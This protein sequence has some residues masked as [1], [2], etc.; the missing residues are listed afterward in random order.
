MYVSLSQLKT[1]SGRL[2]DGCVSCVSYMCTVT[3]CNSCN[4]RLCLSYFVLVHILQV[5]QISQVT[6]LPCELPWFS[7][8]RRTRQL[9]NTVY[10]KLTLIQTIENI[11]LTSLVGIRILL[12]ER[13]SK[14]TDFSP[15]I[16]CYHTRFQEHTWMWEASRAPSRNI[17]KALKRRASAESTQTKC[18][19]TICSSLKRSATWWLAS[20][21]RFGES[22]ISIPLL[23]RTVNIHFFLVFGG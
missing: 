3:S 19:C 20:N 13:A 18:K 22:V 15:A 11:P 7:S 2:V 16:P 1:T 4:V 23:A 6:L 9:C 5:S 10:W 8:Y 17:D 14:E 12:K 21:S